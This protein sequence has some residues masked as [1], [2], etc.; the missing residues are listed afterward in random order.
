MID[1]LGELKI[2][3]VVLSIVV[4]IAFA[5]SVY[6]RFSFR[7]EPSAAEKTAALEREVEQ[8]KNDAAAIKKRFDEIEHRLASPTAGTGAANPNRRKRK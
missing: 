8:S 1:N 7:Q 4:G 5:W 2:W 3:K 6:S